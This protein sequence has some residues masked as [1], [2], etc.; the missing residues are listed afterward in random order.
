MGMEIVLTRV[1]LE[2]LLAAGREAVPDESCGILLGENR[3]L[4]RVE[5]TR[6]VHP[7]PRTHF[8]IDPQALVEAH[9]AARSGGPQ[10]LGYYHSHPGGSAAPSETDRAQASG[11]GRVWAIIGD[12]DV[13]FW[14]DGEDGFAKLS[15]I[16]SGG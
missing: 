6:N 15:Y 9:R 1:L 11:D 5:P 2:R 14:R 7:T 13:A 16:V 3:R 10:V 12:G 8:E 4:D